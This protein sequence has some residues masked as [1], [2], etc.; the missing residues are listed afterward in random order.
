MQRLAIILIVMSFIPW[1][2]LFYVMQDPKDIDA[3]HTRIAELE[4]QGQLLL[5]EVERSP[6]ES[7]LQELEAQVAAQGSEL[8]AALSELQ[9][10]TEERDALQAER[11]ELREDI[12]SMRERISS[13]IAQRAEIEAER[14]RLSAALLARRERE[15]GG[16]ITRPADGLRSSSLP[17]GW[18]VPPNQR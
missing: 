17:G 12:I 10:V 9:R 13:Q 1:G 11:E 4:A 5:R 3:L 8:V 2:F 6:E 18:V 16:A 14:D 7:A 15:A